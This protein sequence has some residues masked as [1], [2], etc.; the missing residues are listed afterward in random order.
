M[1]LQKVVNVKQ[2]F[3]VCGEFYDDSPRKVHTFY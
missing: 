3:G 1:S 2:G